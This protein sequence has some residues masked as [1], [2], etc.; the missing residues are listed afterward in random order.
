MKAV[1]SRLFLCNSR[2]ADSAHLHFTHPYFAMIEV[3][4]FHLHVVAAL[5]A[6]TKRWQEANIKESIL[7]LGL[8][9]LVFTIG[10]AI[11]GSIAKLITPQGGFT[12]WFTADTMSLVLLVVPEIFLFR[13]F[14]LRSSPKTQSPSHPS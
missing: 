6:F 3:L 1:S 5:Y 14:F 4:I 2:S 7:A 9:G 10:W 11:T 12:T 13:L 8:I